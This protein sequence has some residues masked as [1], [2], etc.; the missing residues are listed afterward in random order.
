MK[1]IL[2]FIVLLSL[3]QT[4]GQ[5][6]QKIVSPAI[7]MESQEWYKEQ[8]KL[9]KTKI[10]KDPGNEE[11]WFQYYRACNYTNDF[12]RDNLVKISEEAKKAV[13]ESFA[14]YYMMEKLDGF[15]SP[16]MDSAYAKRPE[17]TDIWEGMLVR[18][19]TNGDKANQVLFSEKLFNSDEEDVSLYHW[20]YNILQSLEKNAI[21][22]TH[23]DNDTFGAWILQGAKNVRSDVHVVNTALLMD[24]TYCNKYWNLFVKDEKWMSIQ[25]FYSDKKV[26]WDNGHAY[27]RFLMKKFA[28]SARPV[29]MTIGTPKYFKSDFE[30]DELFLTGLTYRYD[31]TKKSSSI[32]FLIKN[33]ES[34]YKLEYIEQ[35]YFSN[36]WD[37]QAKYMA[38]TYLTGLLKLYVHYRLIGNHEKEDWVK[39]LIQVIEPDQ[40]QLKH[41]GDFIES[42]T[43]SKPIDF[44]GLYIKMKKYLKKYEEVDTDLFAS[45]F[46]ETNEEYQLFLEDL[47][48]NDK[49]NYTKHLPDSNLW[50]EKFPKAFNEPMKKLYGWHPAYYEYPVVN[51]SKESAKA[52]CNWLT[53]QY[54]N[55]PKRKFE[56]VEFRLPT[57]AEWQKMAGEMGPIKNQEECYLV[58]GKENGRYFDDGGFHM[59]KVD[60]YI[61]NGNGIYCAYG[62]VSEMIS[63]KDYSKGGGWTTEYKKFAQSGKFDS[64]P[65][66]AVGFRVFM[67]IIQK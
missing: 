33:F 1:H 64:S 23:G 11:N 56:K 60:S 15:N 4:I 45:S 65:H 36:I 25:K 62:N 32:A 63:D 26:E 21:L 2:I 42:E 53:M 19:I 18:A 35:R 29:H 66:P 58:N 46:E 39:H 3:N 5:K 40:N 17:Y 6:A 47:R 57:E 54:N 59:V 55:D 24:S 48:Y 27:T 7:K 13:P 8:A 38:K 30:E 41:F 50:V 28:D 44:N 20:G 16:Y 9:W 31:P 12:G 43:G 49:E 52:Y 37:N 10:D 22:F 51:I 34:V 61:E 67:K 14:Y